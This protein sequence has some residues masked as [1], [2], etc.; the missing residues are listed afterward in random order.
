MTHEFFFF[1]SKHYYESEK[2]NFKLKKIFAE[3]FFGQ[4][5]CTNGCFDE[6]NHNTKN[7]GFII[8]KSVDGNVSVQNFV[9]FRSVVSE[10]LMKVC[11]D[12]SISKAHRSVVKLK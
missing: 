1:L 6:S 7:N 3:S 8:G 10:I 2:R 11:F 4:Y 12:F 5:L 9:E